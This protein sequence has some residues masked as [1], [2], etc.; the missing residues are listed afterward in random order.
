MAKC[1]LRVK[2]Y[3]IGEKFASWGSEPELRHASF[4]SSAGEGGGLEIAGPASLVHPNKEAPSP[5]DRTRGDERVM[6]IIFLHEN[7]VQVVVGHLPNRAP[8]GWPTLS[9]QNILQMPAGRAPGASPIFK[10][11]RM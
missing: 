4:Q 6:A 11:L 2:G 9:V 3:L 7:P 10:P 8:A 5:V 1:G